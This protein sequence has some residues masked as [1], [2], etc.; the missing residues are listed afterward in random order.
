MT[1]HVRASDR[2]EFFNTSKSGFIARKTTVVNPTVHYAILVIF[3]V[4]GVSV[5]V[6]TQ[7]WI[8]IGIVLLVG[9]ITLSL[10]MAL[11]RTKQSLQATE[12]MNALFSSVIAKDS[13]FVMISTE[14]GNIAY[15][16]RAFQTHFP[17]FAQQASRKLAEFCSVAKLSD[18]QTE[19][20]TDHVKG[21]KT[22][23]LTV[24]ATD[25][26]GA[27]HSFALNIQGIE[28]PTG[29]VLITAK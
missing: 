19:V 15:T 18:A 7:S 17:A 11:N 9:F 4:L 3:I 5:I 6:K 28:R 10:G 24:Q 14:E 21:G 16:N 26:A 13:K 12:F 22:G 2:A 25:E 23:S 1:K 29:F 8:G 20:L 27:T